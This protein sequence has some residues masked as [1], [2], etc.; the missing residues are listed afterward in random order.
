MVHPSKGLSQPRREPSGSRAVHPQ[1]G[2]GA[3]LKQ[4]TGFFKR[5]VLC[6]DRR[7]PAVS[8]LTGTGLIGTSRSPRRCGPT[9]RFIRPWQ[10]D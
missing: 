5:L 10:P 7:D 4:E 9:H 3:K 8:L 1:Q 6:D 2:L